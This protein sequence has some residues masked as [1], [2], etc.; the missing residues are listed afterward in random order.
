MLAEYGRVLK[1][2]AG[3]H[4]YTKIRQ[5]AIALQSAKQLGLIGWDIKGRRGVVSSL[6]GALQDLAKLS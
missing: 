4:E 5:A 1:R 3:N 6:I 2:Y